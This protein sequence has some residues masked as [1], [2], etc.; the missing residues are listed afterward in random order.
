MPAWVTHILDIR[1]GIAFPRHLFGSS[2][3]PHLTMDVTDP[4]TPVLPPKNEVGGIV[5][6]MKDVNVTYGTR[7]VFQTLWWISGTTFS[8][9]FSNFQVLKNITWQINQGERWHLQ[10]ANGMNI[11]V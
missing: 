1:D 2:N 11:L 8:K 10:G 9:S 6:D 3:L 5:V 7:K 4:T